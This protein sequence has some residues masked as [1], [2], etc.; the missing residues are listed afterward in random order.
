[1]YWYMFMPIREHIV[2]QGYTLLRLAHETQK[3]VLLHISYTAEKA[4]ILLEFST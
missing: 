3:E 4:E 1:M 2:F